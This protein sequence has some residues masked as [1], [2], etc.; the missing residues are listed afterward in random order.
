[1]TGGNGN[2]RYIIDRVDDV[3]VEDGTGTDTVVFN[4]AVDG[5][6]YTLVANVENL[7]LGADGTSSHAINGTGNELRNVITGNGA[8]NIL[9]GGKNTIA[10]GGDTLVGG[11]GNDTYIVHNTTDRITET[12]TG[13]TDTVHS[14]AQGNY[15]LASN[16]ENLVLEHDADAVNGT[17]NSVD[18]VLTGNDLANTLNGQAGN[19]TLDGGGGGDSLIGGSGDDTYIVRESGD[20]VN[21]ATSGGS[22]N[23]TVLSYVDFSLLNTDGQVTGGTVENLTL[24]D[25]ATTATG[26]DSANTLIGNSAANSI[27]GGAGND[28]IIGGD[29]ADHIEGGTGHDQLF[30]GPGDDVFVYT[31]AD[32]GGASG[33]AAA[34]SDTLFDYGAGDSFDLTGLISTADYQSAGGGNDVNNLIRVV[35]DNGAFH[36]EIN[37]GVVLHNQDTPDWSTAFN[38]YGSDLDSVAITIGEDG[39][40]YHWDSTANGGL[41]AFVEDGP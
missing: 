23:D 15:T 40:G 37:E 24:L 9:D 10:G 29:G 32:F 2:D 21:E 25:G 19:D 8:S 26:N 35:G 28:L 7:I 30:G 16:V 5:N 12:S 1:L 14:F 22:G 20:H 11:G 34:N 39:T 31:D 38:V 17:G 13:G 33:S 27:L 18:N 4:G 41:G 36:V 6:T 3:V